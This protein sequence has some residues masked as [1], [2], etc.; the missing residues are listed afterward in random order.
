MET[1]LS[2]E[3]KSEQ[4]ATPA[5]VA[6]NQW[7]YLTLTY[8]TTREDELELYLD[9]VTRGS[10]S[11][12]GGKLV[13]DADAVL[14]LAISDPTEPAKARFDGMID[15]LRIHTSALSPSD[16]AATY[17][18]GY[19]DLV[20]TVTPTFPPVT[21]DS[22]IPI[23][24]E[25]HKYGQSWP[26]SDFNA[27]RISVNNAND[28]NYT[29]AGSDWQFTIAPT[30]PNGRLNVSL[31]AGLGKDSGGVESLAESFDVIFGMPVTRADRLQAWWQFEENATSL[32]TYDY[33]GRFT[34]SFAGN[35]GNVP[36]F[37]TNGKFGQALWL[38]GDTWVRTNAYGSALNV[39]GNKPRTI[40][41]WM[42][43]S[44]GQQT[45]AGP[46]GYGSR[47]C[48]NGKN[49]SFC[50][51]ELHQNNYKRIRSQHWCWDP[52]F[53]SPTDIRNRWIHVAHIYTGTNV[54]V[55]FNGSRLANW[56]R[57][58]IQTG[59]NYPFQFGRWTDETTANRIFLGLM[60]DF[61]IYDV[62]FSQAEIDTF[63]PTAKE[64]WE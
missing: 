1:Y 60:D 48:G 40:S 34:G 19:G 8:D 13:V 52:Q 9:G 45:N 16:I 39:G 49:E 21:H 26:I 63:T 18:N 43:V 5:G 64:I 22:P 58:Q 36:K 47:A 25:F 24:L 35:N 14:R 27:S 30:T 44:D 11:Q 57:T 54:Q 7:H 28:G 10:W 17:E 20:L 42:Y 62:A 56:N 6:N 32:E 55:F 12:F 4:I 38:T 29:G 37:E 41:F 61:R 23:S 15:D 53:N 33:F 59:E 46:Y 51:R 50:L 2:T 3:S 31:Q